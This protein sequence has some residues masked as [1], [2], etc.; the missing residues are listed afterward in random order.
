MVPGRC[1]MRS[2]RGLRSAQMTHEELGLVAVLALLACSCREQRLAPSTL[3]GR[4]RALSSV[5][6][7]ASVRAPSIASVPTK[8]ED[9]PF[10]FG[11]SLGR[12]AACSVTDEQRWVLRGRLREPARR[13]A[14]K[15]L[16]LVLP[17]PLRCDTSGHVYAELSSRQAR[18]LFGDHLALSGA[19]NAGNS[20]DSCGWYAQIEPV[21]FLPPTLTKQLRGAEFETD[22]K[23]ELITTLAE[24]PTKPR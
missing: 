4:T 24:C 11:T 1:C 17:A 5:D 3:Q 13:E 16:A 10:G 6:Q 23:F 15:A 2:L 8:L 21:T 18:T 20:I 22:E 9:A 14:L 12:A 19:S 7:Q